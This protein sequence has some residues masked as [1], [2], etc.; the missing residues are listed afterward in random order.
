MKVKILSLFL[1]FFQVGS[2]AVANGPTADRGYE[3]LGS[4]VGDWEATLSE[5][6]VIKVSY[7]FIADSS[8]LVETFG[9][10]LGQPTLTI[11]H[12][13]GKRL[14]ATH[15]CA[16]GNQPRLRMKGTS[17]GGRLVFQFLDATNLARSAAP[18]LHRLQLVFLDP[19]HFNKIETYRWQDEEETT[20]YSF[21]RVS[22]R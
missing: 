3:L 18:H 14:I 12:L 13:D 9:V 20:T 16:Q 2:I 5:G 19:N 15:Y 1:A 7:Q 17:A 21:S 11:F 10:G 22:P 4:L 6:T 8:A